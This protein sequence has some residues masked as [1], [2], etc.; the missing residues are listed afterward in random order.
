VAF[1][2][3]RLIVVSTFKK[4]Y[5]FISQCPTLQINQSGNLLRI[6]D[7]EKL[8]KLAFNTQNF[9]MISMH[10]SLDRLGVF[11]FVPFLPDIV[12][13]PLDHPSLH[14]LGAKDVFEEYYAHGG[15][16][17]TSEGLL[18]CYQLI[19]VISIHLETWFIFRM[20]GRAIEARWYETNQAPA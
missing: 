17:M 15:K 5:P 12:L 8:H 14:A 3:R 11:Y 9:P 2:K 16:P 13:K 4:K 6:R 20:V 1:S 19:Q 7:G 18:S 10:A